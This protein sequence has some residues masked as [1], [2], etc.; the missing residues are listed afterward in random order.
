MNKRYLLLAFMAL[1]LYSCATPYDKGLEEAN[2][3]AVTGEYR[4]AYARFAELCKQKPGEAACKKRDEARG[5]IGDEVLGKIKTTIEA[6]KVEGYLPVSVIEELNK[7]ANGLTDFG[8]TKDDISSVTANLDAE[9][10]KTVAGAKEALDNSKKLQDEG[11]TRKAYEAFAV[12]AKLDPELKGAFEEAAKK[13]SEDLFKEAVKSGEN[14]NWKT[15]A[16]LF[17]DTKFIKA[18]Y[19][20]VDARLKEAGEKDNLA[21][22]L[23]EGD[24]AVKK[25]NF[26]RAVRLYLNAVKY[27]G[28]ESAKPLVVKTRIL[29]AQ[30]Y[31]KKAQKAYEDAQTFQA[32]QLYLKGI[33]H[34]KEVPYKD[35][36][37]VQKPTKA[38]NQFL[39]GIASAAIKEEE[40]G[41]YG[42]AYQLMKMV[43]DVDANF[44]G[45]KTRFNSLQDKI[46]QR[47]IKGL[48]VIPFKSPAQ[49]PEAGKI[50][51]SNITFFLHKNLSPDIKVVEREAIETILKESEL[52]HAGA[53][54]RSR[55]SILS[56]SGADYFLLGDVLDYKVEQSARKVTKTTR[57]QTRVE[58][59]RNPDYDLWLQAKQKQ[60]EKIPPEPPMFME[61]PVIED[62]KYDVVYYKK[63]AVVDIS[64]KVVDTRGKILS[65]NVIKQKEEA[66]D[67]GTDGIDAGDFKVPMKLAEVP[68]DV[69]II[70]KVQDKVI[71]RI[72]AELKDLLAGPEKKYMDDA[73]R[74]EK[75]GELRDAIERY[76][77]AEVIFRKKGKNTQEITDKFGKLLDSLTG[78]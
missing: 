28:G 75:D 51:S 21:Y 11:K 74:H 25:E 63:T 56:L 24:D 54:D 10:A 64:Y 44:S 30:A 71:Q 16:L 2:K 69:E 53:D 58:K 43:T 68:S 66:S 45:A 38:I 23:K 39:E 26:D 42:L 15:A 17:A 78:I 48:A 12:A 60:S 52:K 14:E 62:I 76:A 6:A 4:A 7:D 61:K 1:F 8:F 19:A 67:E 37:F 65:T 9:K 73:A 18:D 36:S 72:G 13:M 22:F 33:A 70:G 3:I 32:Y 29:G 77:D 49:S 50:F 5:R 57:Q 20:G 41:N 34:Y 47:A 55:E 27:E 40:K 35:Q 59:A 31:F 46:S